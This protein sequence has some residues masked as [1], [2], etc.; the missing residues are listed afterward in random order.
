M[1]SPSSKQGMLHCM[2]RVEKP[3]TSV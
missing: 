1:R 2:L 3:Q